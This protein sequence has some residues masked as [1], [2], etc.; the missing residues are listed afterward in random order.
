MVRLLKGKLFGDNG[1]I[2]AAPAEDLEEHVLHLITAIRKNMKKQ[3]TESADSILLRKMAVTESVNDLLKKFFQA[4]H[5]RHRPFFGFAANLF[6]ALI[7]Y[8]FYPKKPHM[9]GIDLKKT[10]I[11]L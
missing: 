8:I 1:Y 6:S 3:Y 4:E 9:R 5:Y 11:T 7:A 2:S 10:L